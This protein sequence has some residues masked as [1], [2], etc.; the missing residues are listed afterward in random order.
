MKTSKP[1]TT[2]WHQIDRFRQSAEKR[3]SAERKILV[4]DEEAGL[5]RA[6]EPRCAPRSPLCSATECGHSQP[7]H[8]MVIIEFVGQRLDKKHAGLM[9]VFDRLRRKRNIALR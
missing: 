7:G 1:H 4:F 6:Y 5:Q 3:L 2:D 9:T 8:H